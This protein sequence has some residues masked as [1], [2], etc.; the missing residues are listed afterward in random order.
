MY[1]FTL[2]LSGHLLAAG[3]H[4]HEHGMSLRIEDAET[5]NVIVRVISDR[6]PDGTVRGVSRH[7]FGIFSEGPRLL[8]QHRYLLV[9]SYENPTSDSLPAVMGV[10]GG[11]FVPDHPEQWPQLVRS[12][13]MYLADLA[14]WEEGMPAPA[15]GR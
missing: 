6:A 5:G 10:F 2:P 7:L 13:P 12:N 4:L 14:G 8:A 11:L 3:G 15:A 9:V 1:E